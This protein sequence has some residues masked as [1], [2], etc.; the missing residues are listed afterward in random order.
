[1]RRVFGSLRA[2]LDRYLRARVSEAIGAT[3]QPSS[4]DGLHGTYVGDGRMLIAPVWGG[5]LH[6]PSGDLSLTPELVAH[7]T[8]DVP[9]TAFV[10]RH[11]RPGDVVFD[12]GANIGLFTLLLG[13]QVWETGKV[14]SYEA[15]PKLVP[16]LRD[17]V[18]MNWLSDRVEIV[19]KAA[20]GEAGSLSFLVPQ[21]FDLCGS[22]KAIEHILSTEDRL[23]D[24]ERV[25]VDAE[26]L[27]VHAGRFDHID[28]I[29]IDV[30][31]AEN[32]VFAGMEE[33]LASGVVRR[34]SFE[35]ARSHF[36]DDWEEFASRLH[37]LQAEGWAF[38][39]ISHTGEPEP[40]AL[41]DLLLRPQVSQVLMTR[42]Y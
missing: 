15:S 37:H 26:P 29:K 27:D 36:G 34:V 18:S 40:A 8:Y 9:F 2:R 38:A 28:L 1:M 13:Y 16:I 41:E 20:A 17:N 42:S 12:V 19:P 31:G 23:D 11:I 24:I 22:L 32:M 10:Q 4:A 7:G 14:I 3:P 33:L 6:A 39:T 25:M 5:R 35:I 21:R 30:E